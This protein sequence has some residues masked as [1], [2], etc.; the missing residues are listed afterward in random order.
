MVPVRRSV[1]LVGLMGT[2]KSTVAALLGRELEMP[3]LDTDRLVEAAAGKSVRTIFAE[4]GE[5]VFRDIESRELS[6]ALESSRPVVLAAAGGVV[7]REENRAV[8]DAARRSGTVCVVWLTA[9]VSELVS[10]T[11]RGTHRPL[12]DGD[13]RELLERMEAERTDL[14]RAVCDIAVSS[15]GRT[16]EDV[17][18][19]IARAVAGLD[20]GA[21]S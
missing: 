7:L 16:P 10:R 18:D 17:A 12:L 4:D 21:K 8:L 14:Y 3:V 15:S 13:R 1:V 6:R 9:E 5:E 11:E 20:S 19:G 2:G